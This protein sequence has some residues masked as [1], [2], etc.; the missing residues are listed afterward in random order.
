MFFLYCAD[1]DECQN[2]KCDN[3]TNTPGS[4]ECSCNKGY[5]FSKAATTCYGT[6]KSFTN[7]PSVSVIFN[8][9]TKL[10]FVFHTCIQM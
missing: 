5:Y 1:E 4:F 9:M 2:A 10:S 6:C 8:N 3:C 7:D